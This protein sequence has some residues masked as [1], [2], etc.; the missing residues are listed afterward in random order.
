MLTEQA[1]KM[2]I[3]N[4]ARFEVALLEGVHREYR[5]TGFWL[6]LWYWAQ[7]KP[8][9][10][11]WIERREVGRQALPFAFDGRKWRTTGMAKFDVD[12]G[13]FLIGVRVYVNDIPIFESDLNLAEKFRSAGT[14]TL[15]DIDLSIS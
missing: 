3:P 2:L 9:Y 8:R 6:R 13:C 1:K 11:A 4:D 5:I 10:K 15:Q 12:E 14:Y 7:G